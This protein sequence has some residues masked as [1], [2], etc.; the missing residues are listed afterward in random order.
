M[1]LLILGF[2][3]SGK[4]SLFN[5]LTHRQAAPG[6]RSGGSVGVAKVPDAR[7]GPLTDMFKPQRVV[8]A[9][10]QY[11]DTP[12]MGSGRKRGG[13]VSGELLNLMQQADAFV[14]VVRA[15]D[16]AE[17]I[18]SGAQ[19]PEDIVVAM[20]LEL[21]FVDLGILERRLDR[22]NASLKGA[23]AIDRAAIEHEAAMLERVRSSLEQEIPVYLQDI[24]PE[25]RTT[26]ANFNLTTAKPIM[27]VL[28][29]SEDAVGDV[30]ALEAEWHE[31]LSQGNREVV[32]LCA[33]LEEELA[34]LPDDE[35]SEFRAS[36]GA[37]EPGR[38]RVAEASYALL[39]LVSFLT[40]GPDEVRAWTIARQTPA[41]RAA[42]KVHSDIE[43]GFIRAEVVT[44]DHLMAA[45]GLP[46]ARKAGNLRAEGKT[47]PVKDG[48][49]INFLFSV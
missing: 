12:A 20:D 17:D 22:L 40:V 2:S 21:A 23:R 41:Q 8:P 26:L 34:Q 38:D 19:S 4:T 49:I 5:A 43:R 30:A 13:G 3:Q 9:E 47:Y 28:N 10:I 31:R 29:V 37:G 16:T 35:E 39:G 32:A 42:G 7:L 44:Y 27:V 6:G 11:I 33:N 24:P 1:D 25:D 18:A 14:H 48:D 46:A 45:G 36:L 15:F